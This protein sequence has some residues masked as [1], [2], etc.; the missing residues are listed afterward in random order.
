[1]SFFS[2]LAEVIRDLQK[3]MG[4]E[5][6]KGDDMFDLLYPNIE[7]TVRRS[8]L[9]EQRQRYDNANPAPNPSTQVHHLVEFFCDMAKP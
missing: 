2:V 9:L 5:Y 6:R 1:L 7:D 4:R 8:K 3:A